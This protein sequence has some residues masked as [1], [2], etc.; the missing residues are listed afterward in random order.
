MLFQVVK[1][2]CCGKDKARIRGGKTAVEEG[3]MDNQ[4]GLLC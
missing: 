4:K 2:K 1:K 3:C